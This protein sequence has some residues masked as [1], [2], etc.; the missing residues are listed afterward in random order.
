MLRFSFPAETVELLTRG[1]ACFAL[2]PQE[3][4]GGD[5]GGNI[6][7]QPSAFICCGVAAKA[8]EWMHLHVVLQASNQVHAPKRKATSIGQKPTAYVTDDDK[9]KR[10]GEL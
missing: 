6:G 9:K 3:T 4:G 8:E 2:Q 7:M 5:R 10:Q 1:L